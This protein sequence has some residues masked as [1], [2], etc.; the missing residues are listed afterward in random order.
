MSIPEKKLFNI[1][2]VEFDFRMGPNL[3]FSVS[4][5]TEY[6]IYKFLT[7][8]FFIFVFSKLARYGYFNRK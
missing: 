8:E 5:I 2:D 6:A 3:Y 1:I 4:M 7:F